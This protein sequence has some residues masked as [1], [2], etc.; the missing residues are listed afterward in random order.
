MS[1]GAAETVPGA[2]G[3]AFVDAGGDIAA[4]SPLQLFWRRFR[5]DRV[6]VASLGFI[7]LLVVIALAAPLLVKL[8]GLP[9]PYA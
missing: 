5:H 4:R 1:V 9:G 7:V 3:L 8:F 6:A 2:E